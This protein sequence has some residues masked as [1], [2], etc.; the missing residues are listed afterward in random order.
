M[1]FYDMDRE[2]TYTLKDMKD[3]YTEFE[4]EDSET[5]ADIGG[6]IPY[7]WVFLMDT[8]NGRN[9]LEIVGVTPHETEGIIRR[10]RSELHR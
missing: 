2:T 6:F 4:K 5:C 3:Y 7:M 8:V 10:I 9:N 1:M